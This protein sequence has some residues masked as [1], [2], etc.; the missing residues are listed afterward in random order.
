MS[1]KV[2]ITGVS[3]GLGKA[4]AEK[5]LQE[6]YAVVG[7]GRSSDL[8]HPNYAFVECDLSN[9]TA[10]STFNFDKEATEI[11]LINNAGQI[12]NIRRLS[13][14]LEPDFEEVL[15]VNTLAPMQLT[16]QCLRASTPQQKVK[17]A[18]I[19]SGA[20]TRA[21]PGWAAYCASK[22]ALDRFSETVQLEEIEKGN[23]V[24]IWSVAPGV[25]DTAM[26]EK[27]RSA[28]PNDFS[29]SAT[30]LDLKKNDELTTPQAAAEKLYR[31][32]VDEKIDRVVCSLREI[33]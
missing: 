1:T 24:R 32:I 17:I 3:R 29:S 4:A 10:I 31:L 30:F 8:Q 11:I 2:Y 23:H 22:A 12:G 6:G 21:I 25:L 18:N 5:F 19:S 9:A 15:Q 13:D 26:Q 27:I 16:W 28:S 14:Q 7:I 20:A 33:D